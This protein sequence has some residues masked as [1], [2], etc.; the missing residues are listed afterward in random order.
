MGHNGGPTLA[1]GASWRR[2]C[3]TKARA[4]LLPKLPVEV[5][6][7]RVRRAAEIGLDYRTYAGFRATTGHD[8]VAF[9]F[10]TN[11]LSLLKEGDRMARQDADKLAAA[12]DLARLA[13]VHPPLS[14]ARVAE[15]LAEQGVAL[16]GTMRAPDISMSWSETRNAL[17]G[18][19]AAH[20]K[21]TDGVVVIGS[22]ALER[23]WVAAGALAGFLPADRYFGADAAALGR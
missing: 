3:W 15:V 7:L 16:A 23:D 5:V 22:T 6:R 21:P 11:A 20:R 14:P 2:H 4:D 13:A 19:L 9:L 10:S 17:R 8:I 12:R 18:F 1:P